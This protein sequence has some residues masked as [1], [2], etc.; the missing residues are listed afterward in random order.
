MKQ[1]ISA[2]LAGALFGLGLAVSG[3]V[4]PNKVL[5]FLDVAGDWDPSL[6]L[7]MVGA[8]FTTTLAYHFILRQKHPVF[9]RQFHLPTRQDIDRRLLIGAMLFGIGWGLSGYCPGP[10]VASL[11]F[12]RMDA[13]WVVSAMI[14]GMLLQR[15]L[16]G[17]KH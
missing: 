14:A 17:S 4:N 16:L 5:G 15:V 8:V 3:M 6:L 7:V 12:A 9:D 10:A 11:G 13:A 1:A 2:L